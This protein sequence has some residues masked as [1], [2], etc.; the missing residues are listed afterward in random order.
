MFKLKVLPARTE[1]FGMTVVM[2]YN[3]F[4]KSLLFRKST[5]I[6][7]IKTLDTDFEVRSQTAKTGLCWKISSAYISFTMPLNLFYQQ[8]LMRILPGAC[9]DLRTVRILPL[10]LRTN[11]RIRPQPELNC[12]NLLTT[13]APYLGIST[14]VRGYPYCR[15]LPLQQFVIIQKHKTI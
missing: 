6:L 15:S 1:T 13:F 3:S 12:M 7:Y 4:T 5:T 10:D 11:M 2:H 9:G 14:F 8:L